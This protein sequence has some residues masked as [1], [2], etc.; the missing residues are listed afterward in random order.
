MYF[1]ESG[2]SAFQSIFPAFNTMKKFILFLFLSACSLVA[3]ARED[4]PRVIPALQTWEGA[5]GRLVLPQSGRITVNDAALSDAAAIL[6]EDLSV[7]FGMDYEVV[8]GKARKGD[9]SL[10]LSDADAEYGDE[11]YRM[12]IGSAVSIAAPSSKGAFWGTRTLLQMLHNQSEG[13]Q[14]GETLDYPS[15]GW[16]G[17]MIDV[18]RKFFT[19]DYLRQYVKIMSFYK[20]NVMQVHLN[21]NGFVQYFG[22]DWNRTYSA[23]RLESDRFP[24]LTARDG[25]YTKDEFRDFQKM[26][27]RYGIEIVPE[28]DVPAHSLAFTHYNP[29][30][31][32]DNKE[33]GMD[34]LDLYKPEVYEFLDTL[35]AEYIAGD[36]PVFTGPYVHIGTDEYN[37]KEAE[38][39]RHFTN[40]YIEYISGFGKTPVVWGSLKMM[41]GKTPVN[42]GKCHVNAWNYGWTDVGTALDEGYGKVVNL[43]DA[44]LYIVPAAHYYHDFLE[45]RMLYEEWMPENM[46]A[47]D[48][49]AASGNEN[50][51][52]AMFAVWN[53]HVGNGISQQDVHFRTFPAL[54]VMSEKL[55][56]GDNSGAV[57][58]NEF[59]A[60]CKT[61]PEAPG[62][63]LAAKV[64]GCVEVTVPDSVLVLAGS[65]T[66]VTS[67]PEIGYPYK[68]EFE[69]CPDAEPAV[70]A[71]LFRGP[72]SELIS[73]W[74]GTGKFSF[75][76]DGYEFV[77][78]D[79]RLPAGEWTKIRVEG[80]HKGTSLY[81]DG[82]LAE[83]LEGRRH[84]VYNQ[85]RNRID[86]IWYQETLIFPLGRIGD[87]HMGFKGKLRNVTAEH[88]GVR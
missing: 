23:F 70:D 55:W 21:D 2:F 5:K 28:I 22:N 18:G 76:R 49:D 7:M 4:F 77:F 29:R 86:S 39:F 72:H 46:D 69:I 73:N 16:R 10:S 59:D 60:L 64:E 35:F 9:I 84:D 25:S 36:D 34:H 56:R 57:P 82:E 43:C 52:G 75:R 26:A 53:D 32:A 63:N 33:Y 6:A 51:A 44:Y 50:F 79:F 65:D 1:L 8:A 20:M 37:L 58:F 61:V 66:V 54:Q 81:V 11:A 19:M 17:F 45:N 83:R 87:P 30:L 47:G 38:Q 15:Y 13:L 40:H 85:A 67:V 71:V 27:G 31:A 14:K 62:V 74:H 42:V 41:E 12:D 24:G 80:D 88:T 3:A 48:S 68:V 78:H